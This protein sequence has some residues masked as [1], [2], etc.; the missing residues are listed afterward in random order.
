MFELSDLKT[1]IDLGASFI[2]CVIL[3]WIM[4]KKLD[5][6]ET[7]LTKMLTLLTVVVKE[8]TGFNHVDK[9]L[10]SQKTDVKDTLE[11]AGVK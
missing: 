5:G 11:S 8:S 3:L 2:I 1:F 10:G 4:V 6:I 9:V 7:T